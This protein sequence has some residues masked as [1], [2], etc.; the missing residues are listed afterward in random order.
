M[1]IREVRK[2]LVG[3]VCLGML[4]PCFAGKSRCDR[5]AME[6]CERLILASG[7]AVGLVAVDLAFRFYV[8]DKCAPCIN[9]PYWWSVVC[10]ERVP[11][12]CE[13]HWFEDVYNLFQTLRGHL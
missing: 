13:D 5:C 7:L 2:L 1:K 3:L 8:L 12:S 10:K 4:A 11:W 6:F 9:P